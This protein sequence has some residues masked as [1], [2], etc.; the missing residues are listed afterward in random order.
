M[1]I[2]L[3]GLM[4]PIGGDGR[5]SRR[6]RALNRATYAA[7]SRHFASV[8]ISDALRNDSGSIAARP[9]FGTG[10]AVRGWRASGVCTGCSKE[11]APRLNSEFRVQLSASLIRDALA[12]C[13]DRAAYVA[14]LRR[15]AADEIATIATFGAWGPSSR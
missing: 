9:L 15:A 12:K 11:G 10:R 2:G 5:E 1:S 3:L 7:R 6:Q 4:H 8:A 14:R 13:L